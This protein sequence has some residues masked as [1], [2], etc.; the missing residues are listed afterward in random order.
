V[1][2]AARRSFLVEVPGPVAVTRSRGALERRYERIRAALEEI[3]DEFETPVL[4]VLT[5]ID[6]HPLDEARLA[7]ALRICRDAVVDAL[8]IPA[9]DPGVA[10]RQRQE[11]VV[12]KAAL[13]IEIRA[14]GARRDD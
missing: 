13:R 14:L 7:A 6:R 3:E 11:P 12:G 5:R 10:W 2:P 1:E 8:G 9:D 4:V